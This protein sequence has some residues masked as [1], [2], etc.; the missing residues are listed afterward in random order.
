MSLS[1]RRAFA[2]RRILITGASG[3]LGK[4]WLCHLLRE[5][6][7]LEQVWVVLRPGHSADAHARLE[8]LLGTSPAFWPLL[9]GDVGKLGA[10]DGDIGNR[11]EGHVGC[12]VGDQDGQQGS[13]GVLHQVGHAAQPGLAR[14]A[15]PMKRLPP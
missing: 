1:V 8:E 12:R 15:E 10:L 13:T 14:R 7:E 2:G 6:P 3:F 11:K 5:L 9:N 4:V